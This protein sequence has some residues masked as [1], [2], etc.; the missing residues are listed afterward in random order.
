LAR[1]FRFCEKKRGHR[2]TGSRAFA[3][4]GEA[5]FFAVLFFAGCAGVVAGIVLL[6]VP[7]W[8]VNHGFVE[9]ICTIKGKR[10]DEKKEDSG[11][12]YRPL[13]KIEYQ[14]HGVTYVPETYDVHQAYTSEREE[15]QAALDRFQERQ[16]TCWYDPANPGR[17][18]LVRGYQWW[19]WLVFIVPVSFIIIGAGGLGYAVVHWGKS[20]ECRAA[21]ARQATTARMPGP[22]GPAAPLAN[23]PDGSDIESSP[24]TRLAFRLPLTHSPAWALFGLLLAAILWNGTVAVFAVPAVANHVEGQPDWMLSLFVAVCLAGGIALLGCFVRQLLVTTGIGPTLVEISAHPLRPGAQYQLFVSQSGRLKMN[25][26][27]V[28]LV[29]EEEATFRQGTNTR[30]ETRE[31][32]RQPVLRREAFEIYQGEPFESECVLSVPGGVMHSFKA[33]HNEIQWKLVVH[34]DAANWAGS[35]R[36][37]PVVVHPSSR[38]SV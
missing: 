3:R 23:V 22:G 30:T 25:S 37:F 29:C 31:V 20:A 15:A 4:A 32:F 11:T 36:S 6:V 5:I 19:I 13:I 21:R 18:V 1:N 14:V 35:L 33:A 8:R 16:Q 28:A 7:E 9:H 34:G 12:L 26:L 27:E 38:R 24:G 2:R 10:I 17:A